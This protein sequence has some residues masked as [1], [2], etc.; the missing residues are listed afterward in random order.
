M[1]GVPQG[2]LLS[3]IAA[4]YNDV[5]FSDLT[6]VTS[7]KSIHAHKAV[8]GPR[9]AYLAQQFEGLSTLNLQD[10]DADSVERAIEF[11]Y[12]LEYSSA[13]DEV[14]Y[15]NGNGIHAPEEI[16]SPSEEPLQFID[17]VST[18]TAA[19]K[20]KDTAI[21]DSVDDFLPR[22]PK[23]GKKKKRVK[24]QVPSVE[25]E[26]GPAHESEAALEDKPPSVSDA[27]VG[28]AHDGPD[29][30]VAD[31]SRS[32][33]LPANRMTVHSRVHKL[34]VKYGIASLEVFAQDRFEENANQLW[35]TAEFIDVL[36]EIYAKETVGQNQIL[37]SIVTVVLS[38]HQELLDQEDVEVI[39][40][41]GELGWDL[42]TQM[43]KANAP[44]QLLSW[45]NFI[46]KPTKWD[47][48]ESS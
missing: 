16:A 44:K 10:D 19:S 41:G 39:A 8:V 31:Q 26:T 1:S 25:S 15:A 12:K 40:R 20:A 6:I 5:G 30:S 18:E 3:S 43:R 27:S 13:G 37:R 45:N 14:V 48:E 9:S 23:K 35:N 24:V 28:L 32:K 38:D 17:D 34:S 11:L 7:K 47:D 42:L 4:L 46:Q 29:Q 22:S 36:K 33:I 2:E 21:A